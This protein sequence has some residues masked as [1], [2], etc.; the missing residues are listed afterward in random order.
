MTKAPAGA[1]FQ[2]CLFFFTYYLLLI[3]YCLLRRICHDSKINGNTP[4]TTIV[5]DA[6]D[7][8]VVLTPADSVI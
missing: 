7:A 6:V 1:F 2:S 4:T 8:S 3:T 5:S